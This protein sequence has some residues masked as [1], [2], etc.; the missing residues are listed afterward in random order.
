MSPLVQFY[1]V[2]SS[3]V[4]LGQLLILCDQLYQL[5][6][7]C[8]QLYQLLIVRDQLY[9]LLILRDQLYQLLIL[10]DQLSLRFLL[11]IRVL[12]RTPQHLLSQDPVTF[13]YFYDQVPLR[14]LARCAPAW[15]KSLFT[16]T[17]IPVTLY[18]ALIRATL[19]GLPRGQT[20]PPDSREA[21]TD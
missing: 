19:L 17:Q 7:L 9:Q 2:T 16:G 3:P 6:I 14:L 8:D 18:R 13:Q 5:L 1:N 20:P 11:R 12:P 4:S 15:R 10:C 21:L